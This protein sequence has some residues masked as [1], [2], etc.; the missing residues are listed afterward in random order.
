MATWNDSKMETI[1]YDK[2]ASQVEPCEVR[3]DDKEIVVT[4]QEDGSV[5]EYRG[6]NNL[7]GHFDLQSDLGGK[8]TLHMFPG[9]IFLEGNWGEGS[10]R[11]FWRITLGSPEP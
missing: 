6:K 2:A 9:S 7:D 1:Y 4:Y 8:A 11:G 3:I 10:D 5:V